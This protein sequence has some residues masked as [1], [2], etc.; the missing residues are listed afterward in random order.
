MG[1]WVIFFSFGRHSG[2]C[3]VLDLE[4]SSDPYFSSDLEEICYGVTLGEEQ[5]RMFLK[6]LR[7][8]YD[9]PN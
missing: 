6:W 4:S 7:L 8:F 2:H 9:R 3:A 1:C 5:H